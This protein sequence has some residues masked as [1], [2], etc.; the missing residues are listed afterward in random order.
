MGKAIVIV[1]PEMVAEMFLV[2]GQ[3]K[4][5]D[6]RHT[7]F[8]FSRFEFIIESEDIPTVKEGEKLPTANIIYECES[9]DA[10]PVATIKMI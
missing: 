1:T 10:R 9:P 3:C 7:H 8:P 6:G 5:V 4:F 2:R